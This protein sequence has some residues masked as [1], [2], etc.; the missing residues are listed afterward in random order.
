MAWFVR[1]QQDVPR[2]DNLPRIVP[3]QH[4]E[5]GRVAVKFRCIAECLDDYRAAIGGE[6]GNGRLRIPQR[7]SHPARHILLGDDRQGLGNGR[8]LEQGNE[9]GRYPHHNPP[10][11]PLP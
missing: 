8:Y 4:P 5:H 9:N 3:Q 10:P 7:G 1:N 6:L 2:I 11:L